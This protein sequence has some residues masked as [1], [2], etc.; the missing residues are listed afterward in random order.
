M[1][2]TGARLVDAA[3]SELRHLLQLETD[4]GGTVGSDVQDALI[5]QQYAVAQVQQLQLFCSHSTADGTTHC[6]FHDETLACTARGRVAVQLTTL[7]SESLQAHIGDVGAAVQTQLLQPTTYR[8][9]RPHT[10]VTHLRTIA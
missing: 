6:Q 9:H 10:I 7:M 3:V 1:D 5:A 4:E 8:R 2:E